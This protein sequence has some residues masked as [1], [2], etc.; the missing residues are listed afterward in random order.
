MAT[1]RNG[2][3]VKGER[4]P[5]NRNSVR[6]ARDATVGHKRDVTGPNWAEGHRLRVTNGQK[7]DEKCLSANGNNGP[8]RR[9]SQGHCARL[10]FTLGRVWHVSGMGLPPIRAHGR[11]MRAEHTH[12]RANG[13]PYDDSAG[14]RHHS[15]GYGTPAGRFIG[16]GPVVPAAACFGARC[17]CPARAGPARDHF[18]PV[19]PQVRCGPKPRIPGSKGAPKTV[20][21]GPKTLRGA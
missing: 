13:G 14:P 16:F 5:R 7:H 12:P 15:G 10:W 17:R 19:G 18:V 2:G 20:A 21:G 6:L 4:C 8:R 11:F 3:K 9:W 1:T